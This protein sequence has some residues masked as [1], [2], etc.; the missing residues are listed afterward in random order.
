MR[1]NTSAAVAAI[2][3]TANAASLA[4]LC[5]VSNVQ[6]ALPANGTLLGIDFI[7]STITAGALY[8][9]SAAMQPM[10]SASTATYNYCNVTATFT[11]TG[12]GDTVV[13]KYALPDPSDFKNRFYVAGGSAYSLSS[14]ATGGFAYGA[15]GG[16]TS[17]GYDAFDVAYD[18]VALSGN[19]TINWDNAYAFGFVALGEMTEVGKVLTKSFYGLGNN[20]K[21]YTY[22]EGCSDGGREAMSQVQRWGTEYDGVI[23]GAP[24]FR[25]AQQQTNHVFSS[26]VEHTMDYYPPPCALAKIVNA[27]ISACDSLDGRT[28]GVVSRTDLCM[29]NFNLSSIVGESYYCEA[30]NSTSLGLG[31]S[32]AGKRKRQAGGAPGS[33]TSSLPTQNGTVTAQDVAVAQAIYDGLHNSAGQRAYLSWQIAAELSDAAT[34]YNDTTDEWGLELSGAGGEYVAK[35]IQLH[36]VSNLSNLDGVTYDTVV[37]WMT[38]GMIRYLDSLQTTLPDLTPFQSSGGKLLHYH[39]ESDPSVPTASSVHYWQ[40][41]RSIM[42]GNLTDEKALEAMEDWYQLYLVPGAAHCGTNSLQPGPYPENNMNIMIDWVESGVKPSRLN[43]T[44]TSGA[45][46]G[47]TQF[48][49]QWPTRPLW[50]NSSSFECVNDSASIDSWTYSFPAF[51]LPVY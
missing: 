9:Q 2:L 36:N 37:D 38:T 29:L 31:F 4:D 14:D 39:G 26:V 47:E 48:L 6:A 21:V 24:A 15:A 35:F 23:A 5:T 33:T 44:V 8:N 27:T 13:L 51:K 42:Y 12:R 22:F 49:C 17:A 19:G 10:S 7:P 46:K 34:T 1:R 18:D 50:T 30:S 20:T 32:N 45:W 11:H 43:A 25:Y 40:S 3:T 28:D 41:V 16:A